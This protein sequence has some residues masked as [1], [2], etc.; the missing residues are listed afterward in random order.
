MAAAAAAGI[1]AGPL[2]VSSEASFC[3]AAMMPPSDC[4]ERRPLCRARGGFSEITDRGHRPPPAN[5]QQ[6]LFPSHM[7]KGS[8]ASSDQP[9][10]Q[11]FFL[12]FLPAVGLM[13]SYPAGAAVKC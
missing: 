10:L 3:S 7:P 4:L 13:L 2:V 6:R 8:G 12:F 1:A 5:H 11:R 9:L